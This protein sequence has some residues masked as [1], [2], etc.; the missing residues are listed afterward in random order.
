M[1]VV[2]SHAESHSLNMIHLINV[3]LLSYNTLPT[4]AAITADHP[5]RQPF[6]GSSTLPS[7]SKCSALREIAA[8][9][10]GDDATSS[11]GLIDLD[12][13]KRPSL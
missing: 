12:P 9:A 3:P 4:S 1:E 13:S 7:L 2:Y 5:R 10:E 6:S 11:S 8:K